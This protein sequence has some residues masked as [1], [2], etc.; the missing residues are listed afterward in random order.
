MILFP[1]AELLALMD[2]RLRSAH[3]RFTAANE[4]NVGS[5]QSGLKSATSVCRLPELRPRIRRQVRLRFC[6]CRTDKPVAAEVDNAAK[7]SIV[8]S[9]DSYAAHMTLR[10]RVVW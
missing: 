10:L 5:G 8:Y 7:L 3:E 9:R 4:Q 1:H 6:L 2:A